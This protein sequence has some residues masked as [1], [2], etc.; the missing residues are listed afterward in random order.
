MNFFKKPRNIIALAGAAALIIIISAAVNRN[1][2][3][4]NEKSSV[5]SSEASAKRSVFDFF[6]Q[7]VSGNN[8][9]D[10]AS[11]DYVA[12]SR[13]LTPE[14]R[15]ENE[16]EFKRMREKIPG[17][18]FIPGELSP[19]QAKEK[20]EMTRDLVYLGNKVSK[21]KATA[22][23]TKKYYQLKVKETEDKVE[24]IKYTFNRT[25]ELAKETG[26]KYFDE[27][28]MNENKEALKNIEKE[29]SEYK[30]AL[31]KL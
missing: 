5:E 3:P 17:N 1:S 22:E 15:A 10:T 6:G 9:M 14:Q 24:F 13:E 19:E 18:M 20:E 7:P 25:E 16:R 28:T 23:E 4:I 12:P 30:E 11:P 2:Q 27:E 21:G 8:T 31:G 26:R 29:L